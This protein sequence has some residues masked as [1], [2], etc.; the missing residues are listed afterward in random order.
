MKGITMSEDEV[1][2][3]LAG[4]KHRVTRLVWPQPRQDGL[5]WRWR[6]FDCVWDC[7]VEHV[8][9]EAGETLGAPGDVFFVREPWMTAVAFD[10]IEDM[11]EREMRPWTRPPWVELVQNPGREI[12][13][14]Y[15]ADAKTRNI[16]ALSPLVPP[17]VDGARARELT[18]GRWRE[19]WTMP[20]WASRI[21]VRRVSPLRVERACGIDGAGIAAEG[22]ISQAQ[23]DALL[24]RRRLVA[25]G[26]AALSGL[27][28]DALV[29]VAD[30]K[31]HEVLG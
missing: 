17:G 20:K 3:L 9:E 7:L 21:T 2:A 30:I 12:P 25:Q 14:A 27:G 8:L 5:S 10:G 29:V 24:D 6:G 13:L 18:W 15:R 4:H 28:H 11:V 31:L 1:R 26:L 22:C 23:A 19:A 16:G